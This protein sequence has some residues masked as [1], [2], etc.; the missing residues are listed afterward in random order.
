MQSD[1]YI[2]SKLDTEKLTDEQ[3]SAVL[4]QVRT[5][6]GE[7]ISEQ[8]SEEQ[9]NEYQQIINE[10]IDVIQEWLEQNVPEYKKSVVYREIAAHVEADPEHNNPEKIFASI[11]WVELNVPNVKE[12]TDRVLETFEPELES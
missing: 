3:K 1:E 10:D 5:I 8:L 9:L 2:L 6:I 7:T 12:I 11:A 4:E